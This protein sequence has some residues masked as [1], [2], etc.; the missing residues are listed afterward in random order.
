M[1]ED[2]NQ[3]ELKQRLKKNEEEHHRMFNLAE[4]I[5]TEYLGFIMN[6][7]E[8]NEKPITNETLF[9]E[10]ESLTRQQI[11]LIIHP[12]PEYSDKCLKFSLEIVDTDY[13]CKIPPQLL[14]NK[15][16]QYII[17]FIYHSVISCYTAILK[18][19]I[20]D[21]MIPVVAE[22]SIN[23]EMN[24]NSLTF[25]PNYIYPDRR[26]ELMI[27]EVKG[28]YE[29]EIEKF[30]ERVTGVDRV[31]VTKEIVDELAALREKYTGLEKYLETISYD[32]EET[33][34]IESTVNDFYKT[35]KRIGIVFE[36]IEL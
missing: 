1:S 34:K 4:G 11:P 33:D 23:L 9:K 21:D 36:E 13:V 26:K 25:S 7:G 35:I 27:K 17:G 6:I 31:N 15:H 30:N 3:E 28:N 29:K 16:I 2:N 20:N 18:V 32:K 5:V 8:N 14:E 24:D 22:K 19:N 10:Q 12:I